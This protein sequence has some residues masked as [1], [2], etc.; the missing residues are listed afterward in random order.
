MTPTYDKTS[1]ILILI[2]ARG[3]SKGIPRKNLRSLNGQPLIAYAIRCA[4]A[5]RHPVSVYVTSEDSEIIAIAKKL[6]ANVHHRNPKLS[7]DETTL[8]PVVFNAWRDIEGHEQLNYKILVTLQPTS[9]LLRT[10]TL[11]AA[12]DS[13]LENTDLDTV[14]SAR[15][16][17]HLTWRKENGRFLPNY[18]TRMNRQ[19]L[20]STY[21]ETGGFLIT[22]T[23]CISENNRIGPNIELCL[24]TG[25][26][27]VDIDTQEDWGLCE[28]HLRRRRILFVVVGNTAV[29]LGHVYRCLVLA[30]GIMDHHIS[31]L[32]P[33]GNELAYS[34]IVE[35][36]YEV[37]YQSH[38]QII[39]DIQES[40]PDI[41]INDILDTSETYVHE[42]KQYGVVVI[43]FEDLGSGS[44][45]ADL[46]INAL[47]P[48]PVGCQSDRIR[49]GAA[50]FCARDEFLISET[51]VVDAVVKEVL[52]TFGVTDESRLT[53]KVL[54]A[55]VPFCVE[56][57]IHITAILG[58]GYP[59]DDS[60][61]E[62]PMVEVH[63][64][65]RTIS[66]FM[67]RADIVVTS[68]GRTVYEIA[69]VG[70]P[71]IVLGQNHRETTHYFAH[72][73]NGFLNLGLGRECDKAQ[74]LAGF[75]SL[76]QD[77][78]ARLLASRRMLSCGIRNARHT[79]M[80]LIHSTIKE[81]A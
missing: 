69:C 15:E 56:N 81:K 43:N 65:I 53:R 3:G 57:S 40:A 4:L 64:N 48:V 77:V 71:A 37:F 22:R 19:Y 5:S 30:N 32:I 33:K 52:L 51:K 41:V 21:A 24:L 73:E 78:D 31:F 17:T 60:L 74:I 55:I 76:V 25:G 80:Q 38:S 12:L 34:L 14:L 68:A 13:L 6:G 11:D 23:E 39:S 66:D 54:E 61:A 9:P 20:P 46:V 72:E 45:Y 62:W 18:E 59:S 2:P 70:T 75:V 42:L 67:L 35:H 28:F 26:E 7:Q 16:D 79:V 8:D 47:Y 27:E 1:R 58:L 29:G 10:A 63:R 50:Y 44:N 36:N 49:F